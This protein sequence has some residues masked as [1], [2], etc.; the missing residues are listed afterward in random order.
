[1]TRKLLRKI[2]TWLGI[3]K[4]EKEIEQLHRDQDALERK[5]RSLD[6]WTKDVTGMGIDVHFK[7]PHMILIFTRMGGGQIRHIPVDLQNMRD[8]NDLVKELKYRY[9]VVKPFWDC[10]PHM[11][12]PERWN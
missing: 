10:P 12:N 4:L 3:T 8:L 2:K 1:M 9:R 5:L 6:K 7:E 11:G